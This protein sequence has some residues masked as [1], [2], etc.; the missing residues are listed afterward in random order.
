M[1]KSV[2]ILAL[3]FLFNV[4]CYAEGQAGL[5][6]FINAIQLLFICFWIFTFTIIGGAIVKFIL[7]KNKLLIKNQTFKAFSI[8]FVVTILAMLFLFDAFSFS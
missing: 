1:K 2:I 8:S 4:S 5:G 3:L 6:Q 7:Q